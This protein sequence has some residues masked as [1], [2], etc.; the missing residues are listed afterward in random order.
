MPPISCFGSA[1]RMIFSSPAASISAIQLRRSLLGIA[2]SP[3]S[4]SQPSHADTTRVDDREMSRPVVA[5]HDYV[6]ERFSGVAGLRHRN[7][8]KNDTT[9]WRH[10]SPSRQ[11][12]EVFVKGEQ[13]A[14]VLHRP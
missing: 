9:R 3:Y 1:P 6:G 7:A 10:R 13:N 14:L 12:T 11:F 8:Q 4:L 5:L 2:M